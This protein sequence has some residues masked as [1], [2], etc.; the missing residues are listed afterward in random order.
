MIYTPNHLTRAPRFRNRVEATYPTNERAES[1]EVQV[2]AEAVI[3]TNGHV[4]E[5]TIIE[6]AGSNF[7]AAAITALRQ[8]TFVP[9]YLDLS[10]VSSRVQISFRFKLK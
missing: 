7:D 8:S 3:D 10:P 4:V 9:G 6:S 1:T 2:L 5:A